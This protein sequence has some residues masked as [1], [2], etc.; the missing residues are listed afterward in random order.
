MICVSTCFLLGGWPV[1]VRLT[2]GKL[3]G[4]DLIISATGVI[5][6]IQPFVEGN[7]VSNSGSII[8]F[9]LIV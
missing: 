3:Y 1:Y 5:P 9:L 6:N 4:C 2:N 7:D 8:Q